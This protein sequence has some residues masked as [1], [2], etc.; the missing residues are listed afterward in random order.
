MNCLDVKKIIFNS[1]HKIV[2]KYTVRENGFS[3][4]LTLELPQMFSFNIEVKTYDG[5]DNV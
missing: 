2:I 5:F 4:F 1:R 3:I